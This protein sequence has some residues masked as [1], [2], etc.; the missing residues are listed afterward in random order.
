M[1]VGVIIRKDMGKS[2]GGFQFLVIH[3]YFVLHSGPEGRSLYCVNLNCRAPLGRLLQP[4][5]SF[6]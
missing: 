1:V 4:D 2:F 3:L 6:R 5:F